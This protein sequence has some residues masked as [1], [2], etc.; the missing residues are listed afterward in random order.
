MKIVLIGAGNL[1]THLGKALRAAGHDM[2]QVFSRTMQS[3]ETLASLLDAEPLTDIAQVRDDADVYIFSV[4]D[5][6]LVQLVAQLCRHEADGLG[7][8]GAVNALRKAKKGEHERVFLHTAG[9]M[10]MSVFKG[11]AQHYGVLYPMQTFSK[12][13]EVDFSIIPC[14]VEANDEFAQKQ[15]EGL[16]R[17]ISGRVYQLSSEDRKY[18]H[19]SAVFACNFANHCYAISQELLEEHGIPFDVMLPL[20]NETAAKVHE[21]KPKDAQTGPAVRYDE[22]VIDKQSKLLE[23]HPHFKKVYD[24]MSKSIHGLNAEN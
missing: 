24:S 9:S 1:A 17:E 3:A 20:I 16:A 13:R 18:L 22:N 19:L 15:I 10:P 7:E 8:D 23:N 11:M 12:Q 21:M 6:A 5:S 2:L 4:K 14:F